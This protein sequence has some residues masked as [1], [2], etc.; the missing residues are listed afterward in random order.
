M[1][2]YIIIIMIYSNVEEAKVSSCKK[3]YCV[4]TSGYNIIISLRAIIHRIISV[5]KIRR[6]YC[7]YF[8]CQLLNYYSI[9]MFYRTTYYIARCSSKLQAIK[10]QVGYQLYCSNIVRLDCERV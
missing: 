9:I 2:R 8:S 1:Y 3:H 6:F 5:N 10:R 7:D 4:S